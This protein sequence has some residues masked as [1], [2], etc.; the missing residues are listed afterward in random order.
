MTT[1]EQVKAF[2][3]DFHQKVKI[4]PEGIRFRDDRSKNTQ[5]LLD[6]DISPRQRLEIIE[7]LTYTDFSEGPCEDTLHAGSPL[8]IFGSIVK[9]LSIYIKISIGPLN[10]PCICI[11]FHRADYEMKY[12]FK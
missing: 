10:K 9:K 12:P 4:Y 6:L 11:S 5:A 2:L 8:W 1:E 3:R 7:A